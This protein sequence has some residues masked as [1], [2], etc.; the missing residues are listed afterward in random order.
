MFGVVRRLTLVGVERI[1][2]AFIAENSLSFGC[3]VPN[4]KLDVAV[5]AGPRDPCRDVVLAERAVVAE[6]RPCPR[7]SV[8]GAGL[9]ATVSTTGVE[10]GARVMPCYQRGAVLSR[11]LPPFG[12][13]RCFS[14]SESV[15][16][17]GSA[18]AC[19]AQPMSRYEW[20]RC[21]RASQLVDW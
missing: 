16:S 14:S 21:L 20:K 4:K 15:D 5:V 8:V 17:G 7:G 3:R 2:N 13:W 6:S 1:R 12:S 18:P 9:P 10:A 19:S 11:S